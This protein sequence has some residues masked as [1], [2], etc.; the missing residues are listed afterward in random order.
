[1]HPGTK[2]QF[3][4]AEIGQTAEWN[5]ERSLHWHLLQYAVHQGVQNQI[6]DLNAF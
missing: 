6:K 5:H 3:M 1:M 2:L 4:G